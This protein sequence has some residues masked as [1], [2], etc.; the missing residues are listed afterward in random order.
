[1]LNKTE[2]TLQFSNTTIVNPKTINE[3]RFEYRHV[4]TQQSALS[5][6]PQVTVLGAFIGG[7]NNIGNNSTNQKNFQ[8]Q[9][10]TSMDRG[11]H[12]FRFGGQ[13]RVAAENDKSNSNFNGSFTFASLTAFQITQQGLQQGLTPARIRAA[14]GGAEQFSIVSGRPSV[15]NT[16]F[17]ASAFFQ[18]NWKLRPNVTFSY[19][20]RYETQNEIRDHFDFAPR[21]GLAVG[22]HPGKKSVTKTV[23][24]MGWGMFY[25]RFAQSLALN[26]FR[27]D[28][29]NQ[30]QFIVQNPDFFPGVLTAGSLGSSLATPTLYQI[31]PNL[32][33]PYMMQSSISIEQKLP[34]ATSLA[35]TYLSSHGGR[36]L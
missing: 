17:D 7:G 15:A 25:T 20:L 3:S 12:Y 31:D 22:I 23:L 32:R 6:H 34:R 28:G 24:R 11:K 33:A 19:G 8:L 21:L 36:Q 16:M 2:H 13:V 5:S 35:I 4:D 26:S 9:N 18:D 1:D 27:L 14:G 10:Y 29:N 30:R